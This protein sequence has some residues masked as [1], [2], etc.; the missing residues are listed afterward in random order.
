[1]R[2]FPLP[3]RMA[4][5]I[6]LF[7]AALSTAG[8]ARGDDVLKI[9]A[10]TPDVAS[11]A[12]VIGGDRV[13]VSVMVKGPEDAHFAEAKPSFIKELS[14]AD[15]YLQQGLDLEVGYAP[16]LLQNAR[17]RRVIRGAPGFV[18]AST[19]IT[20]IE[21]PQGSID[22]SMG[23]VH[24]FGN[25]HY[26]LDPI[27]GLKVARLL[28]EKLAALAPTSAPVFAQNLA[29]FRAALGERL[30]GA[31]LANKYDIEKLAL[32]QDRGKLLE[33]LDSQGDRSALAGWVGTMA[34][35][36]GRAVVDDHR[37]WP[38]FAARF[39]I[40]IFDHL[41]PIPGVP[42]TTKH[43]T[44]LVERMKS[45]DVKVV[46]ASSYYDPRHA[47]FIAAAT[48]AIVVPFAHQTGA[49]PGTDTYLDMIDYDVRQ[50]ATALQRTAAN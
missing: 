36:K 33:F 17:N 25:P 41:E 1:M 9:F 45:A 4:G 43:L 14:D 16:L 47:Q 11:L 23:D 34:P 20:P 10:T 30:F 6:V 42:P 44:E 12:R 50:I 27:N 8:A 35:F 2:S 29:A 22:R 24:P 40:T 26:L 32:L 19:A 46:I 3:I 38:Y 49:R 37:M 31:A 39:G 18:D 15:V 28:N 7:A 48:G 13:A 21:V 5:A